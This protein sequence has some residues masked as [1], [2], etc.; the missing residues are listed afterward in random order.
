MA[1]LFD[2]VGMTTATT[3]T[4]AVTLG[5]AITDAT[6]GDLRSFATAGAANGDVVNYLITDGNAWELG[7]GTYTASG[8]TLS[9]TLVSSSTGLLLVLSGSANVYCAP[10]ASAV[11]MKLLRTTSLTSSGTWTPTGDATFYHFM[12]VG[13]GGPGGSGAR[14]D[15]TAARGGGGGGAGGT[16]TEFMVPAATVASSCAYTIG[17][18]ASG[19]A[20]VTVDSTAGSTSA[21]GNTTQITLNT[22]FIPSAYGGSA[23]AGGGLTTAGA[24][25][26]AQS[27]GANNFAQFQ[28][29]PGGPGGATGNGVIGGPSSGNGA[30][31][32]GGGGGLPT[33]GTSTSGGKGSVGSRFMFAGQF[34]ANPSNAGSAGA[35]GTAGGNGTGA[36]LGEGGGGG[37]SSSTAAAGAGG[38]G[39]TPGGGGGGGAASRNGFASG[40]G[41]SGARGEIR[42]WEFG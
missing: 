29:L 20:A 15:N 14:G 32:G 9:R 23:G 2:R 1:K 26:A 8:T 25:G 28:S 6:N 39:G 27:P 19:S 7:T 16:V 13:G 12:I 18:A 33:A 30:G 11:G 17:A 10:V 41:G 4:G 21:G 35:A 3:G 22:A 5:S 42:I 24:G 36:L 40:A 31:A 34:I 37:S 38:N